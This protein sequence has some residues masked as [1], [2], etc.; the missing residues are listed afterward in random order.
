[1]GVRRCYRVISN[2]GCAEFL[3][4]RKTATPSVTAENQLA[5][6][7]K[8]KLAIDLFLDQWFKNREDAFHAALNTFEDEEEFKRKLTA[9]LEEVINDVC[10]RNWLWDKEI[11]LGNTEKEKPLYLDENVQFTVYRPR[12]LQVER[13]NSLLVF[14]DLAAK[15]PDAPDEEPDPLEEVEKAGAPGSG[16][17]HSGT[18]RSGVRTAAKPSLA[19]V[20]LRSAR[21]FPERSLIRRALVR[22]AGAGTPRGFPD[23]GIR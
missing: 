8:Q 1:M 5:E 10:A 18:I 15:R 16:R 17:R 4:Y 23:R 9:H 22:V 20:S 3:V 21:S 19:R 12:M 2:P 6:W 14:A 13:C 7:E 11:S